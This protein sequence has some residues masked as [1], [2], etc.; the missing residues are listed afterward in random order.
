MV[1]LRREGDNVPTMFR[2]HLQCQ[3][4]KTGKMGGNYT[5][6]VKISR[7]RLKNNVLFVVTDVLYILYHNLD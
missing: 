4:N 3:I 1:P 7:D 6:Q 2:T 5:F